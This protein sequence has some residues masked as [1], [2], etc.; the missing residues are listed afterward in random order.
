MKMMCPFKPCH[1]DHLMVQIVIAVAVMS[2]ASGPA[3]VGN[4]RALGGVASVS[5]ANDGEF[6]AVDTEGVALSGTYRMIGA[7]KI[8]F[9]FR[10]DGERVEVVDARVIREGDRLILSFPGEDAIETYERIP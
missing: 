3:I 4:W 2:C 7:D 1:R 6:Q 10:H 8:Q 9:A 5:F